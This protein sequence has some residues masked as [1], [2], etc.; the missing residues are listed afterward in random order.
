LPELFGSSGV[1]GSENI[2]L[3]PDL[4]GQIGMAMATSSKAK[5]TLAAR[6][7]KVQERAIRLTIEGESLRTAK[8]I[9]ERDTILA[10][11]SAA[12]GK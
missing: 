3:I 5:R 10:K 6:E 9:M 8:K 2:N 11:E 12:R 4:A 7:K 1:R